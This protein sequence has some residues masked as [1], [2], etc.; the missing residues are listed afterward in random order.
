MAEA[1]AH[2]VQ[3][4]HVVPTQ[5]GTA[6]F[7]VLKSKTIVIQVDPAVGEALQAALAGKAAERPLSH[8]L[9][10]NLLKGVDAR[11]ERVVISDVREGVF[12]AKVVARLDGPV[13]SKLAEVDARPSDSLVLAVKAKAPVLVLPAVEAACDDMSEALAKLRRKEG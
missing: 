9:M 12:F 10:L 6:V 11:V 5:S 4:I 8:D 2:P 13:A 1:S 3:Q 7:L